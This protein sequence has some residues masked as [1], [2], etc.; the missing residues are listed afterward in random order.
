MP[1]FV[2]KD[3]K[4][5]FRQ[6]LAGMYDAVVITDPNGHILE[7]NPRAVEHFGYEFDEVV[8]QPISVYVPGLT[9]EVV[10]RIRRGMA[11]N[12]HVMIDAN[13]VAKDGSKIACEITI[14]EIDLMDPADLVFTIRNVERRRKIMNEYKAKSNAFA[15]AGE[16]L[17]VCD[18]DGAILEANSA[19][20]ELFGV[21]GGIEELRRHRFAEFMPDDPLPENFKKALNGEISTVGIVAE[22]DA[23]EEE[24]EVTLGPNRHGRKIHGVVGC[25]RKV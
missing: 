6:F 12:R 1:L 11:E 3:R 2:P 21:E 18:A 9:N 19:F 23:E 17:F 20:A 15:L 24:V 4:S 16:A 13:A 5:L 10:Q 25:V 14:S 8:D 22:G 7:V